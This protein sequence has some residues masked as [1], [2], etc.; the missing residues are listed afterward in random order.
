MTASDLPA[1][2]ARDL[3]CMRGD[4]QIFDA[5][6]LR[7]AAGE[8]WQ[9]VGPNGAGKTS[10]LRILAGLAPAAGGTVSWRDLPVSP[11]AEHL[12]RDLVYLGHLPGV[13]GFLSARENLDYAVRL[14]GS[15]PRVPAVEALA[16][17]GLAGLAEAP[18]RR[19]SAG[20][21]QRLALA[22]FV[23]LPGALWIMD[24]PLTALDGAGRELVEGLLDAH[25]GDG[26]VAIVSTH[27][28]L[29]LPPTRLHRFEFASGRPT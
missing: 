5:L 19:L 22:R 3:V 24:E 20:Q 26:G 10:L 12:R 13:T 18:A 9:V 27:H 7:A 11:G 1:L 4:E 16:M 15:T 21:R 8:V 28:P 17:V 23:M 6:N 2:L 25:A 29:A 14:T